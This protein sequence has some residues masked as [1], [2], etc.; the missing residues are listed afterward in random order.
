MLQ[1]NCITKGQFYKGIIGKRPWSFSYI[2]NSSKK[3]YMVKCF[4][5]TH[6]RIFKSVL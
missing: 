4:V 3:N 1:V 5:A 2:G 6:G